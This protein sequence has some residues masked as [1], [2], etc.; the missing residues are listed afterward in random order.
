MVSA[1]VSVAH[2][3]DSKQHSREASVWTAPENQLDTTCSP[4]VLVH[5]GQR[6]PLPPGL[7]P[8]LYQDIRSSP[9]L[10]LD[11]PMTAYEWLKFGLT[12]P[13]LL[14]RICLVATLLPIVILVTHLVVAGQAFNEPL[15]RWKARFIRPFLRFWAELLLLLGLNFWHRVKG[16][17]HTA[18][19]EEVSV[20]ALLAQQMH[21]RAACCA[22][23][24]PLGCGRCCWAVHSA[25]RTGLATHA[26]QELTS[27]QPCS[28]R[29]RCW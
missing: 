24:Q 23:A 13:L 3:A 5:R 12:T 4:P 25:A 22:V 14:I 6:Y 18:E 21:A 8:Q 29:G 9:Y 20:A 16:A 27:A 28:R 26:H 1:E 15:P 7:D 19:A 11:S 17:E 10:D 2:A